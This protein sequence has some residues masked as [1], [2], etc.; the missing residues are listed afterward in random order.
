MSRGRESDSDG[1]GLSQARRIDAACNRFEGAWRGGR[2]P[3][4]KD[5]LGDARGPERSALLRELVLLDLHYRRRSG[6]APLRA[7]YAPH[8]AGGV[9]PPWLAAAVAAPPD[10]ETTG[11]RA[12]PRPERG[13]N[14][15]GTA[16]TP[17][18]G[19]APRYLGGYELL[20][21]IGRGAMGV[22]YKARQAS[23]PRLVALKLL[24][25]MEEPSPEVPQRFQREIEIAAQ[26][27]HPH[28]VPLYEAGTEEGQ[29]YFSMQLVEGGSLAKQVDRFMQD[30]K[31]AARL[32]VKVAGAVHHA[33]RRG[34]LHR[35]LKPANVL[36]DA[37]GE[38]HVTDFGLATRLEGQARLTQP[39]AVIGTPSYMAPEQAAGAAGV[40][41]AADVYGLGSIL[42]ELL[43]GQPPFRGRTTLETLWLVRENEPTR[44]RALNARVDRDLEAVCLKC[45]AKDPTR[46][47][48][49]A[50]DLAEDLERWLRGEH[51]QARRPWFAGRFVKWARR[52]LLVASLATAV[53][54]ACLV[55]VVLVVW[56]RKR[57]DDYRKGLDGLLPEAEYQVVADAYRHF[58]R[59]EVARAEELLDTCPPSNRSWEWFHLKRRC[60]RPPAAI[61]LQGVS[62][63]NP[64]RT[65]FL[66]SPDGKHLLIQ[67]DRTLTMWDL[68]AGKELYRWDLLKS[69]NGRVFSTGKNRLVTWHHKHNHM[70][71]RQVTD[72]RALATIPYRPPGAAV[73][74]CMDSAFSPDGRRV[75]AAFYDGTV[76]GWD[77]ETR[78]EKVAVR[79]GKL[80]GFRHN[81]GRH[82]ASAGDV[83]LEPASAD[84]PAPGLLLVSPNGRRL[85]A[86]GSL[87][88]VADGNEPA[89]MSGQLLEVPLGV[90]DPPAL[91]IAPVD[92]DVV[93]SPDGSRLAVANKKREVAVWDTGEGREMFTLSLPPPI[94]WC[95]P[96]C[97]AGFSGDGRYFY[98]ANGRTVT[99][100]DAA[101]GDEL[102]T[103][104]RNQVP[105]RFG[106]GEKPFY[107]ND[108]F[109]FGGK[110]FL[111]FSPDG[112]RGFWVE[113]GKGVRLF[114]TTTGHMI[115][116][117]PLG[118]GFF[119]EP[120]ET[121]GAWL[122]PDGRFLIGASYD[123]LRIEG[124]VSIMSWDGAPPEETEA[125]RP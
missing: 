9:V 97:H 4:L 55:S 92:A 44:P 39:G 76:R 1:L 64:N 7:D 3:R 50:E 56:Q 75:Y 107:T 69:D 61:H 121:K 90:P 108:G 18:P 38:P 25:G 72:G 33:H 82:Y 53:L 125:V 84:R 41:T 67:G 104:S 48:G 85:F 120:L 28:L 88:N 89:A 2:R 118:H 49:S 81:G 106:T 37:R 105:K 27:E 100:W 32:M 36:L 98:Y 42:Y 19:A 73:P 12:G 111:G 8:F 6:D 123:R 68:T 78:Q 70:T 23:P 13:R 45:L 94:E 109:L 65:L 46:R 16:A 43:T 103:V 99:V 95:V 117:T 113:E 47:Y 57:A 114:G 110:G 116:K 10:G 54:W 91:Q 59:G 24:L 119:K 71:I 20:E 124:E 31:A 40:T 63:L 62:T 101:T 14:G 122:S 51:V 11:P 66:S 86:S 77:L 74:L 83:H 5:Y 15:A 60:R 29:P 115:F 26:F 93:F 80:L 30:P 79:A 35:D 52:R 22:V 17:A 87:W 58:E 34:I 21:E 112:R 102:G 96:P